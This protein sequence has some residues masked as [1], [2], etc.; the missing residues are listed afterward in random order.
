M[1]QHFI[2]DLNQIYAEAEE[3]STLA[4]IENILSLVTCHLSR[5][6]FKS[7]WTR[8][9]EEAQSLLD[10]ANHHNFARNG[11][12]VNNPLEK[13]FRVVSEIVFLPYRTRR[14]EK[15]QGRNDGGGQS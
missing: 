6:C 1:W 9:L 8:K 7:L 13:G 11:I 10:E 4:Y 2:N 12:Y 15:K 3:L 5:L 14:R